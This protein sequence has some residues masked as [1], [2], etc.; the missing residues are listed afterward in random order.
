ME[1]ERL[2]EVEFPEVDQGLKDDVRRLGALVGDATSYWIGHR[3]GQQLRTVWP[4]R[5]YPQLLDR[6]EL[7]FRRNAWKSIFIARFVGPIRPF[8]PAVAGIS[9]MPLRRYAVA[10]AAACMRP[11]PS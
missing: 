3:W 2:R 10:S 5:K 9:R 7:L 8:V 11:K 4:F 6:G 1:P